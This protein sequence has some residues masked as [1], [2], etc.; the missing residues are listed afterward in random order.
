MPQLPKGIVLANNRHKY[1]V[2][3][4]LRD[5]F[6]VNHVKIQSIDYQIFIKNISEIC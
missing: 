1:W 3:A 4:K 2:S 6:G 5:Q